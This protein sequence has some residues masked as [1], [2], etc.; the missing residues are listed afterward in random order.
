MEKKG[1]SREKVS[2]LLIGIHTYPFKIKVNGKFVNCKKGIVFR[3]MGDP[4][5]FLEAFFKNKEGSV[6]IRGEE[7]MY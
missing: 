1:L 3:L 7:S 6:I 5:K 4:E 2:D